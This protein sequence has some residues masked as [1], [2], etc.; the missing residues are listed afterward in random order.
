MSGQEGEQERTG[1]DV[2]AQNRQSVQRL[3]NE[4]FSQGNLDVVDQVMAEGAM[5]HDANRPSETRG[6]QGVRE[7]VNDY[8]SAFPDL[9]LT[10]EAQFAEGDAVVTRWSARGTQEGE[11]WG[12]EP[13]G[14]QATVTGITIDLFDDGGMIIESWTNWDALGLL[15][16]LGAVPAAQ[17]SA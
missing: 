13:T 8:R 10:I 15:Q 16:Q 3:L 2:E 1:Q 12:L 14:Q 17:R 9:E 11:L 6:P 5:T 7:A 4:A